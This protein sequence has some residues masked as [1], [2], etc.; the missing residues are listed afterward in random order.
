MSTLEQLATAIDEKFDQ[1]DFGRIEAGRLLLQ[2]QELV[3]AGE[4]GD[5]I[6]W[7]EWCAA[8]ISRSPGDIRKVMRIARSPDPMA[9]LR[10]ERQAAKKRMAEAR[11]RSRAGNASTPDN[12]LVELTPETAPEI[13]VK[14][15]ALMPAGSRTPFLLD[16]VT[17]MGESVSLFVETLLQRLSG[18]QLQVLLDEVLKPR[19][20]EKFHDR[21]P[22][23]NGQS[24]CPER[25]GTENARRNTNQDLATRE[26]AG[27]EVKPT[28]PPLAQNAAPGVSESSIAASAPASS[29]A[30]E[31]AAPIATGRA[32]DAEIMTSETYLQAVEL[33]GNQA[34]KAEALAFASSVFRRKRSGEMLQHPTEWQRLCWEMPDQARSALVR[35]NT[36]SR[37]A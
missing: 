29:P 36:A 2:A 24:L 14:A 31:N 20:P 22:S 10:Q 27:E 37:A 9:T 3:G 21:D 28:A 8:Y 12:Q 30:P 18:E 1:S 15:L 19:W 34:D 32:S 5:N 35:H 23:I 7:A 25:F 17:E 11:E 33:F 16:Q 26:Q 6:T 13:A 4:A